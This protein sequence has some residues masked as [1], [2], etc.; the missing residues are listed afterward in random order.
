PVGEGALQRRLEVIRQKLLA[1][2]LFDEQYKLELPTHPTSIGVIT[3][4][5]GAAIRDVLHVLERRY[6]PAN[7]IVYPTAVQ[8]E[9]A[10]QQ[11]ADAIRTADARD[12][13][14]V[15]LLV[16]GGGS[17]EDLWSFNEEVVAWAIHECSLPIVCGVGH[18]TDV[19]IADL[20]AD[21]RAPTPSAAAEIATPDIREERGII[22]ALTIALEEI[23]R[24]RLKQ[25]QQALDKLGLRL[26]AQHPQRR[27]QQ[28]I[29]RTDELE[30]RLKTAIE[31][32]LA[33]HQQTTGF[34][35]QRL[36]YASPEKLIKNYSDKIVNFQKDII[37]FKSKKIE[38]ERHRLEL[39]LQSLHNVSPLATLDR[40]YAVLRTS[41]N[42]TVRSI[43]MTGSGDRL[44]ATVTDGDLHCIVEKTTP[45][46][47]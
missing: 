37:Y 31:R 8:G 47:K 13:C 23:L 2:G 35:K 43:T 39:L 38:S 22:E 20:V 34:L 46:S 16:R 4:A 30:Q 36:G 6:P 15:L 28:K 21:V 10:A 27:L 3:S 25:H 33:R 12:E 32:K 41:D 14:D 17:L 7:V 24:N 9:Q 19:T 29:Q 26:Q 40:G 42:K 11:I 5:T 45:E 1:A 44:I 18:E